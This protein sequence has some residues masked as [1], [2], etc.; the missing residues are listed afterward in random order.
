MKQ[1]VTKNAWWLIL[2]AVAGV[3]YLVY[4]KYAEKDETTPTA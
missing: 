1:F 2:V 4:E 3:A